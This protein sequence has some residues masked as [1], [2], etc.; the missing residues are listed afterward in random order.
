VPNSVMNEREFLR[1]ESV[2]LG[3]IREQEVLSNVLLDAVSLQM[4]HQAIVVEIKKEKPKQTISSSRNKYRAKSRKLQE[5]TYVH[6]STLNPN[7]ED[8]ETTI[9]IQSTHSTLPSSTASK[10]LLH[11]MESPE[12]TLMDDLHDQKIFFSYFKDIDKIHGRLIDRVTP[13]PTSSPTSYAHF[14]S[15]EEEAN[16]KKPLFT[17]TLISAVGLC[18]GALWCLLTTITV[19]YLIRARTDMIND[20][21]LYRLAKKGKI[22]DVDDLESGEINGID[23]MKAILEDD[24]C[25]SQVTDSL[26]GSSLTLDYNLSGGALDHGSAERNSSADNNLNDSVN[27]RL[28]KLLEIIKTNEQLE[29]DVSNE[30]TKILKSLVIKPQDR[31]LL[32]DENEVL[33][34]QAL[35][36]KCISEENRYLRSTSGGDVAVVVTAA[37]GKDETLTRRS[38]GARMNRQLSSSDIVMTDAR[39][40]MVTCNAEHKRSSSLVM[41]TECGRSLDDGQFV[42]ISRHLRKKSRISFARGSSPIIDDAAAKSGRGTNPKRRT[43]KEGVLHT[44][45]SSRN[46]SVKFSANTDFVKSDSNH[47][48]SKSL[49]LNPSERS[50]SAQ[51]GKVLDFVK[52]KRAV[53]T[54]RSLTG[55]ANLNEEGNGVTVKFSLNTQFIRS[56]SKRKRSKSVEVKPH[57]DGSLSEGKLVCGT[58]NLQKQDKPKRRSSSSS[59]ISNAA[60]RKKQ[61]KDSPLHS[62]RERVNAKE[63]ETT[64]A[65][66]FSVNKEFVCSDSK[67]KPLKSLDPMDREFGSRGAPSTKYRVKKGRAKSTEPPSSDKSER[68]KPSLDGFS[69]RHHNGAL[70]IRDKIRAISN[71]KFVNILDNNKKC[72]RDPN[73]VME[74]ITGSSTTNEQSAAPL[75]LS[76]EVGLSRKIAKGV[77]VNPNNNSSAVDPNSKKLSE[78]VCFK[79]AAK[80]TQE[81][82]LANVSNNMSQHKDVVLFGGQLN[83][84]CASL[85]DA[86]HALTR[87]TNPKVTSRTERTNTGNWR[88]VR[89]DESKTLA[90]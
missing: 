10:L 51:D 42:S 90:R 87:D 72:S 82:I 35:Q 53:E 36:R 11:V 52:I 2:L 68:R 81:P 1:Y 56:D 44:K 80:A 79:R 69:A 12:S 63:T 14:L 67:N 17:M 65:L 5:F 40:E 8:I 27:K 84:R 45:E 34:S 26:N 6:P 19:W 55:R 29:L 46:T 21:K 86:H 88:V 70:S 30:H 20:K 64:S 74:Y 24:T 23:D 13:P 31:D 7:N 37:K 61:E 33:A 71:D 75:L 62:L 78:S 47:V 16:E 60:V 38:S 85:D 73:F 49:D 4:W 57:N 41:Q 48:R 89:H 43:S 22:T 58:N 15:M 54:R 28:N 25:V 59:P 76:S 83:G 66:T 9:I 3:Y 50:S 18:I 39:K 77:V 32:K